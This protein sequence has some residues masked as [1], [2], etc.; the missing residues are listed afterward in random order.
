M[1]ALL[2]PLR[3]GE[4]FAPIDGDTG[5]QYF[6][7]LGDSEDDA[8][9]YAGIS[10][11]LPSTFLSTPLA[12]WRSD[13]VGYKAWMVMASYSLVPPLAIG[14]TIWETDQ[15]GGSERIYQSFKQTGQQRTKTGDP[16]INFNG[17]IGVSE[18]K[19]EG[20]E[21]DGSE[22]KWTAKRRY[23]VGDFATN[24]IDSLRGLRRRVNAAVFTFTW[25]GKTYTYQ[26]GEARFVG[27]HATEVSSTRVEID[28]YFAMG[29][30]VTGVALQ[31]FDAT[32]SKKAWDYAWVAFKKSGNKHLPVQYNTEQVYLTGD[33]SILL[34]S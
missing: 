31:G 8:A 26:I 14:T 13:Y 27:F 30:D 25:Q 18:D 9:A 4:I 19:V 5:T 21:I 6:M 24:Y 20:C 23:V 22:E 29:K 16:L 1:G 34:L 2:G 32:V 3:K 15:T 7:W 10:A 12:E 28:H 11:N 17:A 33:F